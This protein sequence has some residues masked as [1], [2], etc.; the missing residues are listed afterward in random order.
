[1][2]NSEVYSKKYIDMSYTQIEKLIGKMLVFEKWGK[3]GQM[4]S[5]ESCVE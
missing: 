1:M 2:E 4:W 3:S 5:G